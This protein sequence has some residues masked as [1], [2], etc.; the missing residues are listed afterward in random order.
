LLHCLLILPRKCLTRV[1]ISGTEKWA[2]ANPI[3]LFTAIIYGF[4]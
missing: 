3:K 4:A 2:G 1:E